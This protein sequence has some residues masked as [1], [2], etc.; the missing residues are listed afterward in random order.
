MFD[1]VEKFKDFYKLILNSNRL[2][3]FQ[4]E[5]C[6]VLKE[7]ALKDLINFQNDSPINPEIQASYHAYA[8]FGMIVEW[9]NSEFKYSSCYMAN[10]L[11]ELIMMKFSDRVFQVQ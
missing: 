8:I 9:V 3:G 6:N 4:H 1:H 7:L 5:I 11:F 10:Q 2:A